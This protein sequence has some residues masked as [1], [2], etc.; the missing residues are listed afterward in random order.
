MNLLFRSLL[1]AALPI[2]RQL[3]FGD[4]ADRLSALRGLR[5]ERGRRLLHLQFDVQVA[6]L[7]RRFCSGGHPCLQ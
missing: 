2:T 6:D 1:R 7:F 3:P 4:T 5:R